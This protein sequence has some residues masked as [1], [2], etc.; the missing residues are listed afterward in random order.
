MSER[1]TFVFKK[2]FKRELNK[3][4]FLIIMSRVYGKFFM[5]KNNS[6]KEI[7]QIS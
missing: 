4:D 1:N 6:E 5:C 3:I 7:K 2:H